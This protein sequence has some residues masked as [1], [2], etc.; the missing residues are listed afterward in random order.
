MIRLATII[1]NYLWSEHHYANSPE[2]PIDSTSQAHAA[3]I[4]FLALIV[5][6]LGVYIVVAVRERR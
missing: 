1:G 2:D 3:D 5:F 4:A 6:C